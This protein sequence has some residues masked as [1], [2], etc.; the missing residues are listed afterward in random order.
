MLPAE[1]SSMKVY[2]YIYLYTTSYIHTHVLLYNT[3]VND[4]PEYYTTHNTYHSDIWYQVV[5]MCW[6]THNYREIKLNIFVDQKQLKPRHTDHNRVS[7]FFLG[8]SQVSK[9][10][11]RLEN[12]AG[13][14][15]FL[16]LSP[17]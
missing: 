7:D 11:V 8:G 16:N 15:L 9:S 3:A 12:I 6:T 4:T 17:R 1:R 13:T 5:L 14:R 2:I 10:Q